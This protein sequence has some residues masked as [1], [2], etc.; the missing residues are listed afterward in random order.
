MRISYYYLPNF[1][2]DNN[3]N[4]AFKFPQLLIFLK[5]FLT[6]VLIKVTKFTTEETSLS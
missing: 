6:S 5:K 3:T 1:F 2:S 4:R